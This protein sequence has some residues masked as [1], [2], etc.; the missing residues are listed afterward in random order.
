MEDL[1]MKMYDPE[2][3]KMILLLNQLE[4][5]DQHIPLAELSKYTR[6]SNKTIIRYIENLKEHVKVLDIKH[7]VIDCDGHMVFWKMDS[8]REYR[9]L[10]NV[11]VQECA[12]VQLGARLILG[13]KINRLHF[14]EEFF[15]SES[16]FKRRL[17]L[18]RELLQMYGFDIKMHN[19]YLELIGEEALIRR[20]ARDTLMS[21]YNYSPWPF[22]TVDEY[23]IDQFLE[24]VFRF[25]EFYF[26]SIRS[27]DV[28]IALKY[29]LAIQMTRVKHGCTIVLKPILMDQLYIL[30]ILEKKK[31]IQF[32]EFRLVEAEQGY[33]LGLLLASDI[34]Y[35]SSTGQR[36]LTV[37]FVYSSR[38]SNF[39][40][41]VLELFSSMVISINSF[42]KQTLLP[43]FVSIH[44][45]D[46]LF[47]KWE[48][49]IHYQELDMRVPNLMEDLDEYLVALHKKQPYI[50]SSVN[51]MK[52]KYC[53]IV[54]SIT[55]LSFK[56]KKIKVAI[57]GARTL[58]EVQTAK[59]II[60]NGFSYL[61]H[62]EFDYDNPD[63]WIHLNEYENCI[64]TNNSDDVVHCFI[65]SA[66]LVE[67]MNLVRHSLFSIFNKL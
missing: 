37:L 26:K 40:T 20:L 58:L 3:E 34:F 32:D 64:L 31:I 27:S 16:T 60:L 61:Y 56:E 52:K 59:L 51:L 67:D 24:R 50:F 29:D 38:F 17:K 21:L 15:L 2:V 9:Y 44:M 42:E 47:P 54:A 65:S 53:Q 55:Q 43:F 33:L 25:D 46:W 5:M 4:K 39:F 45:S 49:S 18:V 36:I 30:D 57:S 41:C 19:N 23:Q 62:L 7:L 28:I 66:F 8:V 13:K 6:L 14:M 22:D 10:R 63:L 48:G 35:E 12:S 1:V 11:L